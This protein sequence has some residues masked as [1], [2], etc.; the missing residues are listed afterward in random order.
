MFAALSRWLMGRKRAYVEP[1]VGADEQWRVR[2]VGLNGEKMLWSESYASHSNAE[3]AVDGLVGRKLMRRPAT[4]GLAIPMA[5]CAVVLFVIGLLLLFV[6]GCE[7]PPA[8][9]KVAP[10]QA[11][12]DVA[13]DQMLERAKELHSLGLIHRDQIPDRARQAQQVFCSPQSVE[14]PTYPFALFITTPPGSSHPGTYPV[15]IEGGNL[16]RRFKV[17]LEYLQVGSYFEPY[18]VLYMEH[19]P[20]VFS[21][22]SG[23]TNDTDLEALPQ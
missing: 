19:G 13:R 20:G 14:V 8:K 1:F 9:A 7:T 21:V 11:R 15:P 6:P 2:V 10:V 12:V 22:N 16:I 18:F 5:L 3:R 23:D 4:Q 17:R